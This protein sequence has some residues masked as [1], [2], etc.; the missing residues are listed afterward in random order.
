[1]IEDTMTSIELAEEDR[2]IRKEAL[3]QK[4]L[5]IQMI[6]RSQPGKV[7]ANISDE[8]LQDALFEWTDAG[9]SKTW[10]YLVEEES[11]DYS[12]IT[13]DKIEKVGR[14]K[15]FIMKKAA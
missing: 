4:A 3:C 10:R 15:G 9:Y 13:L 6:L 1:M 7:E 5:V 14:A 8:E 2:D 12:S 11:E